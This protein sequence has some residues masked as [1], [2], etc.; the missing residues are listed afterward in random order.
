MR[1]QPGSD[2][3]TAILR[4]NGYRQFRSLIIHVSVTLLVAD[5]KPQPHGPN[6]IR[7]Y[8]IERHKA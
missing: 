5:K 7:A 6:R 8:G 2:A 1:Q 3:F 4:H